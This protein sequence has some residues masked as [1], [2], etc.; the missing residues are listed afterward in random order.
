MLSNPNRQPSRLLEATVGISVA[1]TI[2][3]DLV[4]PEFSV[5]LQ[6]CAVYRAPVPEAPVDEHRYLRGAEDE[7][8]VATLTLSRTLIIDI[9]RA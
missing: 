6:P 2:S 7:I 5:P 4:T 9:V 1:A 8:S 3:L